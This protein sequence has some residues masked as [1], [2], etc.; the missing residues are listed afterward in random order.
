MKAIKNGQSRDKG[1]I[2]H[3]KTQNKD[4]HNTDNKKEEL[5]GAHGNNIFLDFE[6]FH[7][8]SKPE[9]NPI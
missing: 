7:D 6:W 9:I 5:H 2:R 3:K 4:K 8:I 1:N